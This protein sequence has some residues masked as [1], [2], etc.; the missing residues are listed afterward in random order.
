MAESPFESLRASCGGWAETM[1]AYR[2][3]NGEVLTHGKVLEAHESASLQ[4]ASASRR[5][6]LIDDT[7]E[8]DFSSHVALK[9]AGRLGGDKTRGFYLHSHLLVDAD[10]SV[11]LGLLGAQLWTRGVVRSGKDR[12]KRLFEQKESHRWLVGYER[13]CALVEQLSGSEVT[14]LADR[15]A[16]IYEI[17]A[18]WQ[19]R[20]GAGAKAA[21]FVVRAGRNRALEGSDEHLM[22]AARNA[23]MLG[24]LPIE[25]RAKRN[26]KRGVYRSGVKYHQFHDRSQRTTVLEVRVAEVCLRATARTAGKALKPVVL[27]VV[28][29]IETTCPQGEEPIEWILLTTRKVATLDQARHTIE[30]YT[31]RW[32]IEEFHR[33]LKSG[34][35]VE[36]LQLRDG[37]SMQ[38]AIALYMV[39]AWRILYL[40]DFGRAAPELPGALLFSELEWRSLLIVHRKHA[41][42]DPP[43]VGELMDLLG[44]LGGHMGRRS[45]P[46]PGAECLARGLRKLCHYVEMATALDAL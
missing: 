46:P 9:G 3:L 37:R 2:L 40:R 36:N 27:T 32:L 19:Q 26:V 18:F 33:V 1:A 15:E 4:R 11:V 20:V 42:H 44:R 12:K 17:F 29:A 10:S 39:V 31:R 30:A 43:T 24:Q 5:L 7:T 25:L 38:S 35:R 41:G 8:L 6:L 23:P 16:D 13:A 14:F 34:C 28:S 45:D 22:Q 21:D